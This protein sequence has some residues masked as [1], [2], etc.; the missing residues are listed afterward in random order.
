MSRLN[1]KD[2][3]FNS[4]YSVSNFYYWK[5]KYGQTRS[6][7]SVGLEVQPI[8]SGLA[9]VSIQPPTVSL[10]EIQ[11]QEKAIQEEIVIELPGG[12]VAY[13]RGEHAS[14]SALQLL[15]QICR[16]HV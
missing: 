1:I 11:S 13:F 4:A 8:S 6:G 16:S 9:P 10:P 5:R 3:C 2:F 7:K 12:M 14:E 15:T